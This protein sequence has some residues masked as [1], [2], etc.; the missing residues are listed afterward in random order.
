M[1]EI[2]ESPLKPGKIM[3]AEKGYYVNKKSTKN[4]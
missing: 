2:V 4:H 1:S 3:V